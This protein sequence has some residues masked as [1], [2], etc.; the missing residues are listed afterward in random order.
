MTHPSWSNWEVVGAALAVRAG[1]FELAGERLAIVHA[2]AEKLRQP[3]FL[4]QAAYSDAVI[5][6]G[7]G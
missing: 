7:A 5:R 2:A 6:L 3:S 4:W 1:E